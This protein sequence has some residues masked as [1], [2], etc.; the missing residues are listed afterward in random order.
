LRALCSFV[1]VWR[2]SDGFV[3][4]SKWMHTDDEDKDAASGRS[5]DSEW[6][7]PSLET[8]EEALARDV[9]EGYFDL[10]AHH[11]W[12]AGYIDL[13]DYHGW[14]DCP[15]AHEERRIGGWVVDRVWMPEAN[16][17]LWQAIFQSMFRKRRKVRS[18]EDTISDFANR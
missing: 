11:K 2:A 14:V 13:E 12:V 5:T 15:V 4:T 3:H 18:I 1:V 6:S 7:L 17:M 10:K 16:Q 9:L 8:Q